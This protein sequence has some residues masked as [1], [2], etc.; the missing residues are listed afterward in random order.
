[1]LFGSDFPYLTI[2]QNVEGFATLGLKEADLHA[3]NRG[4]AERLLP[5]V[6]A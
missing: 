5:R 6:A 3:I 4:N 1:V 2:G